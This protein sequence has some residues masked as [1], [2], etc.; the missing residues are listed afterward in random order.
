MIDGIYSCKVGKFEVAK[1][2]S[3]N[4]WGELTLWLAFAL[5]MI[6]FGL[7]NIYREPSP[8]MPLIIFYWAQ[9][10]AGGSLF[11][12]FVLGVKG[13]IAKSP[14]TAADEGPVSPRKNR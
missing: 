14:R 9:V 7:E 2:S 3:G 8:T 11:V 4:S 5:V 10:A 1:R 13:K 6:V 12:A